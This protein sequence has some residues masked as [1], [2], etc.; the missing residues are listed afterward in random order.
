[1]FFIDSSICV[2]QELAT[3]RTQFSEV[4][5]GEPVWTVRVVGFGVAN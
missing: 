5:L 2:G 4:R 1:M 3:N